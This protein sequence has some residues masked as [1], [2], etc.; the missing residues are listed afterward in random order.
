M[1][2]CLEAF[3][4][5]PFYGLDL[6][7]AGYI[8]QNGSRDVECIRE[9]AESQGLKACILTDIELKLLNH[10]CGLQLIPLKVHWYDIDIMSEP[11]VDLGDTQVLFRDSELPIMTQV[12]SFSC[13][14]INHYGVH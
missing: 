7:F 3:A 5:L 13:M 12:C 9:V 14:L 6:Q 2:D 8:K 11:W 1:L 4:E 10:F